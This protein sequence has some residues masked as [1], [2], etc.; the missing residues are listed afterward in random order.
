MKR[1]L[2]A[3]LM[4]RADGRLVSDWRISPTT[5]SLYQRSIL[6]AERSHPEI[7]A[8]LE[9]GD[10]GIGVHPTFIY[11]DLA[12]QRVVDSWDT[13]GSTLLQFGHYDRER[14]A[15]RAAQHTERCARAAGVITMSAWD[16]E[17]M[18]SKGIAS[19]ERVHVVPPGLNI[20]HEPLDQGARSKRT[21][22][23]VLFIGRDFTRKAGPLVV[24][25]FLRA[26]A[27]SDIPM[28]L[29]ITG[30]ATWP[31][32]GAIP[33][34][35]RFLGDVPLDTVR[36]EL[37]DT[38]LFV[39][40]SRFEAFGIVFI[41]ALSMGVPVIGRRAFAMPEFIDHGRNGYLLDTDDAVALAALIHDGL[42]NDAMRD[43]VRQNAD[44]IAQQYSW[45]AAAARM[46]TIM[47]A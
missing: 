3:V 25:A 18:I 15:R 9:Y 2:Q 19:R 47:R 35:I 6:A 24:E 32:Q 43:Y 10:V 30:P 22:K 31:L 8:I 21:S 45:D 13:D 27:E 38:D 36:A 44:A 7:E 26:R 4:H 16:A 12:M 23:K 40:P 39:M 37:H 5:Y 17:Y 1:V 20:P 42:T 41:E 14:V 46:M 33:E 34:G 29:T 28:E 11:Q